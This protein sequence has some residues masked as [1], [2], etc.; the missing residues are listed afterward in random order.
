MKGSSTRGK[1]GDLRICLEDSFPRQLPKTAPSDLLRCAGMRIYGRFGHSKGAYVYRTLSGRTLDRTKPS[2]ASVYAELEKRTDL[3]FPAWTDVWVTPDDPKYAGWGRHE[4]HLVRKYTTTHE[5]KQND[6]KHCE[7]LP[8]AAA[9]PRIVKRCRKIVREASRASHKP[10]TKQAKLAAILL[11]VFECAFRIGSKRPTPGF[12]SPRGISYITPE[13][14]R[15]NIND[16]E[17]DVSFTGKWT[18][19]NTCAFRDPDLSVLLHRLLDDVGEHEFV[20]SHAGSPRVRY[21][22]VLEFLKSFA[23]SP[24]AASIFT[25]KSLRIVFVHTRLFQDIADWVSQSDLPKG[26]R[27]RLLKEAVKRNAQRAFHTAT[28]QRKFYLNPVIYKWIEEGNPHVFRAFDE[29]VNSAQAY[30]RL[31]REACVERVEP[32][33]R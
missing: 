16:K 11:L 23:P 18:K 24:K 12:D 14:L 30:V 27:S 7:M 22:D 9:V 8:F 33:I 4:G 19:A 20:F 17:V 13:H 29:S 15:I 10:L 26:K 25:P 31:L 21:A 32:H 6:T 5:R 1:L 28:V 3:P 2:D